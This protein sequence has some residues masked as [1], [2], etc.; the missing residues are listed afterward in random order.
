[1]N[2]QHDITR[3]LNEIR[4]SLPP[5]IHL[6]AI[7]KYHDIPALQAAY[8][9]GQRLFGESREQELIR[10][11]KALPDDIEWHFIGHL[12]TNKVRAIAPFIAC[13]QSVDS[14]RLMA[15]IDKRAK[16]ERR[17]IDIL[18]E[19]HVANEETKSGFRV[20]ELI[21]MLREGA[22]KKLT[23]VR[24]RGLMGMATNTD[25]EKVI[26]ADFHTLRDLFDNVKR[27]F[28]N[29]D[30]HFDTLSMGMTHD[31]RLAIAEGANMVRVGTAIFGPREY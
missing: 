17:V 3:R 13:I 7:S 31:Y 11:Q 28:F 10:K 18:L 6:V 19:A 20:N 12:Q 21:D 29:E 4:T 16:A 15:E 24:V 26:R 14:L 22:W 30:S 27:E 1:M 9:A 23:S 5:Y 25:D 8:D 2:D